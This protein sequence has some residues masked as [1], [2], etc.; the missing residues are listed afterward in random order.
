MSIA[1]T[2]VII[3]N[4]TGT[5]CYVGSSRHTNRMYY[6]ERTENTTSSKQI[7]ENGD[8]HFEMIKTFNGKITDE[9]L[10]KKEQAL[11]NKMRKVYDMNVVNPQNAY[12]S[13]YHK[14][15]VRQRQRNDVTNKLDKRNY[16]LQRNHWRYSWEEQPNGRD[17]CS[18]NNIS[19]DC[20][21]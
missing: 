5:D 3:D 18:F 4:T 1:Y 15:R 7:I 11:M 9:N 2:Y 14:K 6:H 8:Y 10:R 19:W 21:Q 17:V 13:E 20:F 12:T 16:D